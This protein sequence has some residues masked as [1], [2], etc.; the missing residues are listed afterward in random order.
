[1]IDIPITIFEFSVCISQM[2]E[3]ISANSLQLHLQNGAFYIFLNVN[4]I[5]RSSS[6]IYQLNWVFETVVLRS[7][8]QRRQI[9]DR[10]K[11]ERFYLHLFPEYF[12]QN[13]NKHIFSLTKWQTILNCTIESGWWD[14][15]RAV[16]WNKYRLE[17]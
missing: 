1:M 11:W 12:M 17:V 8:E 5:R 3:L 2:F 6:I 10:I 15:E 4:R 13:K 16:K 14:K 9:V 7:D